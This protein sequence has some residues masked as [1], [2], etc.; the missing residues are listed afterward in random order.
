MTGISPADAGIRPA[1]DLTGAGWEMN[2]VKFIFTRVLRV[3]NQP[4]SIRTQAGMAQAP[5]FGTK[6][7]PEIASL[8][9]YGTNPVGGPLRHSLFVEKETRPRPVPKFM[10]GPETRRH[11]QEW[12]RPTTLIVQDPSARAIR[13][14]SFLLILIIRMDSEGNQIF[15]TRTK[16]NMLDIFLSTK[17]FFKRPSLNIGHRHT[18]STV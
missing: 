12:F 9:V 16:L 18:A 10:R 15:G 6:M 7:F 2:P 1:E 4:G 13:W 11:N 17:N 8:A 5:I 14:G 3:A